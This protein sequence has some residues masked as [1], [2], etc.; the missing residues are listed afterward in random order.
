MLFLLF[1]ETSVRQHTEQITV[2][3][4]NK[5]GTLSSLNAPPELTKKG[6]A[7][8]EM[9]L[10]EGFEMLLVEYRSMRGVV[11]SANAEQ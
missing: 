2:S 9:L 4:V 8:S 1:F 10:V 3:G 7:G 6:R 11:Y 5:L